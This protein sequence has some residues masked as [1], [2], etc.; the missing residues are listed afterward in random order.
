MRT[1]HLFE[2]QL[3]FRIHRDDW[4]QFF[5]SICKWGFEE[6]QNINYQSDLSLDISHQQYNLSIFLPRH[7]FSQ[8]FE[9]DLGKHVCVCL[10]NIA[11]I[12]G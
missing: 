9:C 8:E 4:P 7:S 6:F 1:H 10:T 5:G 12:D 11:H 3:D 2:K